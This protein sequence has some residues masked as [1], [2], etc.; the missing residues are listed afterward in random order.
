MTAPGLERSD[1]GVDTSGP[2]HRDPEIGG[3]APSEPKVDPD[4]A[5]GSDSAVDAGA[6]PLASWLSR[7]GAFSVDYLFGMA[8]VANL[9]LVAAASAWRS[10]LWWGSVVAVAV[11]MMAMVVNRTVLPAV[12]GWTL[13]RALFGIRVTRPGGLGL[14]GPWRLLLRDLSHLL[15]SAAVFL[16]WLWPLWD[17]RRRTF[18]DLLLR[19]EVRRPAGDRRDV[20]RLCAAVLLVAVLLAAAGSVLSYLTVYRHEQAVDRARDEI[21]ARGPEI[22]EQMLSYGAGTMKDDFARAQSVVTEG[23]RGKLVEQQEAVEKAG[24]ATNEYWAVA[25][26]VLSVT[27]DRAE[28]LVFLQGQRQAAEQE[29]SFISATVRVNFEKSGEHNWQLAEL[30][31]LT[32]PLYGNN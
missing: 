26:S 16:G 7:A 2:E 14:P 32:R 12:T 8:V 24:A 9:A 11:V 25:N 22:V 27:P 21:S 4:R 29:P 19:T 18:A 17:S 23:Y 31:V 6:D 13:G 5:T 30:T 28:M 20:R 3:P 15:D 10:W 1:S